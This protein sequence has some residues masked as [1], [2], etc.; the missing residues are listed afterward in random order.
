MAV[1]TKTQPTTT[2]RP[3]RREVA[4]AVVLVMAAPILA[5]GVGVT[6]AQADS[7]GTWSTFGKSGVHAQGTWATKFSRLYISGYVRDTACDGHGV[8]IVLRFTVADPAPFYRLYR[9]E[10]V[11]NTAGGCGTQTSFSFNTGQGGKIRVGGSECIIN[12][13]VGNVDSCAGNMIFEGSVTQ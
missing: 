7:S 6:P 1:H 4:R 9:Q 13:G 8:K 3:R 10:E 11:R 2:M 5:L 12:G